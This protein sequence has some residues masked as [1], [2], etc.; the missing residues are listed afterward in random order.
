M[1]QTLKNI[2]GIGPKV[3]YAALVKNGASIISNLLKT[4]K[5]EH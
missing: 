5:N 3:D 1:I 4:R 2:F